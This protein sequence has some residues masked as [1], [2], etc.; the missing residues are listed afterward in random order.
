M[1]RVSK[2]TPAA[3]ASSS[4]NATAPA[5]A[6]TAPKSRSKKTKAT[7]ASAPPAPAPAPAPTT[8]MAPPA[9]R[10]PRIKNTPLAATPPA[11]AKQT[12]PPGAEVIEIPDCPSPWVISGRKKGE[13]KRAA[14]TAS[15]PID[16]DEIEMWTPRQKIRI[17]EDCCILSADPLAAVK[18]S[19]IV[20]PAAADDEDFVVLAERGQVRT[21]LRDFFFPLSSRFF[22][23]MSRG[24][25]DFDLCLQVACRDFPHARYA[26]AK[27]PFARTAHESY[28]E[29]CYCYVCD[30]A[31]PC[32]TWKGHTN[33]GHC[34]ASDKDKFWMTMRGV[35]RAKLQ[36]T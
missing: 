33:Y 28:C 22:P 15:S 29:Q 27:Y 2:T 36:K 14:A 11:T 19:P 4:T 23:Q 5:P 13:R 20:V 24:L 8:Q 7:P 35:A 12:V 17:D 26:C 34:H 10:K 32:K 18:A 16:V 9:V 1:A 25:C 3:A 30:I 6:S 31:A 21:P